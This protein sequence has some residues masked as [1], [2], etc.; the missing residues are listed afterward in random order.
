MKFFE[1]NFP[2][3]GWLILDVQPFHSLAGV[4][5][6]RHQIEVLHFCSHKEAE[7][8]RLIMS[9]AFHAKDSLP[10]RPVWLNPQEAPT[11]HDETRNV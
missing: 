7:A 8:S 3:S 11:Q 1:S 2:A 4:V 5:L 6:R 9:L 10:Q